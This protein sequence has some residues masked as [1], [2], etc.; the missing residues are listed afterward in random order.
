[1]AT[2]FSHLFECHKCLGKTK[3]NHRKRV[4]FLFDIVN[5]VVG[6]KGLYNK[7]LSK[8]CWLSE[9]FSV[10]KLLAHFPNFR[11]FVLGFLE[12]QTKIP[13]IERIIAGVWVWRSTAFYQNAS[14]A[15]SSGFQ[16]HF[17]S[18]ASYWILCHFLKRR[19]REESQG[20]RSAAFP[21]LS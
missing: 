4:C 8:N 19:R 6:R 16:R 3:E 2:Q 9:T 13:R 5:L 21:I 10:C 15:C 20:P 12:W 18:T 17:T 14:C 7:Y 11:E 1:M